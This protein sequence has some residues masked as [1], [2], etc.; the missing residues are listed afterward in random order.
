MLVSDLDIKYCLSNLQGRVEA[1][2]NAPPAP[3][4]ETMLASIFGYDVEATQTLKN[5]SGIFEWVDDA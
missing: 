4:I 5:N 3:S 2:E 1:L